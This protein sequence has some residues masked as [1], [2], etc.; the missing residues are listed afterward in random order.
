MVSEEATVDDDSST[1][2]NGTSPAVLAL[3]WGQNSFTHEF[4][5]TDGSYSVTRVSALLYHDDVHFPNSTEIGKYVIC[6]AKHLE[7]TSW[8]IR[9]SKWIFCGFLNGC[10]FSSI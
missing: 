3:V 6:E 10:S 8:V 5:L 9:S 1:C 4:E 2:G 7:R